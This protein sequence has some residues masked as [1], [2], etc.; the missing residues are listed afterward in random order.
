[1]LRTKL[2]ALFLLLFASVGFLWLGPSLVATADTPS[3]NAGAQA[4]TAQAWPASSP[5]AMGIL[6]GISMIFSGMARLM[7]SMTARSLLDKVA[8]A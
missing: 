5:W 3:T 8:Q 1:M 7:L 2:L 6:V 4:A